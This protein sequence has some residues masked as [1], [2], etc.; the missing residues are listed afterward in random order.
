MDVP[1]LHRDGEMNSGI[2]MRGKR[3]NI[4]SCKVFP[5]PLQESN[6]E[7]KTIANEKH[8]GAKIHPSPEKSTTEDAKENELSCVSENDRRE[9]ACDTLFPAKLLSLWS[10]SRKFKNRAA[11]TFLNSNDKPVI[12][13]NHDLWEHSGG[14]AAALKKWGA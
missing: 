13:T 6:R 5:L 12:V 2:G 10:N 1:T 3:A 7:S 11:F 8:I 4:T 14:I 9:S